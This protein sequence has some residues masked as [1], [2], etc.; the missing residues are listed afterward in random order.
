MS[1]YFTHSR[2]N[3]QV[4]DLRDA[5]QDF[6]DGWA[7]LLHEVCSQDV[8]GKNQPVGNH[9][10]LGGKQTMTIKMNLSLMSRRPSK[11]LKYLYRWAKE[12]KNGIQVICEKL[13]FGAIPAY[14]P[15]NILKVFDAASIQELAINTRW[16]IYTLASLAPGMGR[17]KNLQ[18]LLFKEICIS[19]DR[20][21][22]LEKEARIVTEIFSEFSKLHKLQHLHL[23]N[24][25]FLSERLD[26]MLSYNELQGPTNTPAAGKKKPAE[27]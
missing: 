15:L 16:D 23:H 26:L 1:F 21:W 22:D 25:D 20:P 18:K 8:F 12:R 13:E 4:L 10:I 27:R 3:L 17:M 14:D 11:Y 24:V 5:H 2:W 9:P 19:W 7:G 6:W